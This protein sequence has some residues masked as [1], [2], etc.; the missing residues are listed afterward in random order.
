[1]SRVDCR[2]PTGDGDEKKK[3]N[4]RNEKE[5][6]KGVRR[7]WTRRIIARLSGTIDGEC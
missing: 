6:E 1:M 3:D 4:A 7:S 5:R 2:E